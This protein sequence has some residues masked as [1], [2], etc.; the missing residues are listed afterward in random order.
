MVDSAPIWPL[1]AV[2]GLAADRA[3]GD[4]AAIKLSVAEQVVRLA[5]LR[6]TWE[7]KTTV[8]NLRLIRTARSRRGQPVPWAEEIER[9]LA[10]KGA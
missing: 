4:V 7:A 8:R 10:A 6:E 9:A 5:S 1:R 2:S 3:R